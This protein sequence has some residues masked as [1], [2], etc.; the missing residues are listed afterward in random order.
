MSATPRV[1]VWDLPTRIFHWATATLF[2]L[3][4]WALEAGEEPHEW[5]G[6]ALTVLLFL[7]I[8]WGFIGSANA[9]FV[10][11]WPTPARLRHHREQL[12]TRSFDSA[13]GHNPLGAIMILLMLLLL[14][15]TALS[16]WMQGLDR[17]WGE[18][19]VEELHEISANTLMI[20]V[21]IHVTAVVV[22]SRISGLR[23]IRTMILGWRPMQL[24][25]KRD[26]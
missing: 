4:Y 1:A 9:R 10:N 17:F 6:Y 20:A 26:K 3:N 24:E 5:V 19:W 14:A 18:D 15:L 25:N 21:A 22:M 23:L 12:K 13:E 2:L 7:R 8:I 16:G 11:F